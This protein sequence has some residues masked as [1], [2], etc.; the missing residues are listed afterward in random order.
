[1]KPMN[2]VG[3]RRATNNKGPQPAMDF[4]YGVTEAIPVPIQSDKDV[5]VS[6][7]SDRDRVECTFS[8]HDK[9]YLWSQ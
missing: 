7:F 5:L 1:M 3:A 9:E 4:I 2:H 8:R 6:M